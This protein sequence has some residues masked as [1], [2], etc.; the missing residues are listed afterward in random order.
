MSAPIPGRACVIGWPVAHSRSPLIHGHWLEQY[1]IE[2]SYGREA[3]APGDLAGFIERLN[4]L[5]Y[6]GCNVTLPYKEAVYGL[7]EVQDDMTRRIEAVNTL[8][9]KGGRLL[10]FNSDAYGFV[11]HLR[12]VLPEWRGEGAD[13]VVLGAGGAARAIVAGLLGEGVDRITIANRTE[14]R[15]QALAAHFG[16]QVGTVAWPQ[17]ANRL[18]RCDLLVNTTQLGM[19]GQPALDIDLDGL[20]TGA[21]VADI[22]YVPLETNLLR[23]ARARGHP[24]VDGLGMLLHQAVPGFEVWFGVRPEVTPRLRVRI[25]ADLAK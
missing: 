13:V 3:V 20:P 14:A 17:I 12:S 25:E 10:G 19:A 21:A 4:S 9:M 8:Y 7:V 2:G 24:V 16:A 5:G 22:V 1:G 23:Q 11:A 6:V 15:G 18:T